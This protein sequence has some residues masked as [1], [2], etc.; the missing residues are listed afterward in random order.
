[1]AKTLSTERHLS[2]GVVAGSLNLEK[3]LNHKILIK[4]ESLDSDVKNRG[5][6]FR[7]LHKW[8]ANLSL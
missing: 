8:S 3:E 4:G 1:V 5:Y 7:V 2:S 6:S